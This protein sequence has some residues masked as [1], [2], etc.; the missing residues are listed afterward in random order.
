[1]DRTIPPIQLGLCCLN[2]VLRNPPKTGKVKP[3]PVFSSRSMVYKTLV[4]EGFSEAMNRGY[5]NLQ[6]IPTMLQWNLDH[7]MYVFRLSSELFAHI[8]NPDI[9]SLPEDT[10]T[11]EDGVVFR[12]DYR[13]Y[14]KLEW[15]QPLLEKV[16]KFARDHGIRL[17]FH[18]GQFNVLGTTDKAVLEKTRIELEIHARILDMMGMGVDSIMVIHGGGIYMD[19]SQRER[20][21][22]GR[23]EA[24]YGM[25]PIP[26]VSETT[27]VIG[28]WVDNFLTM[29][30][31]VQRRLVLENCEKS[32]SLED[33]IRVS[34]VLYH[35]TGFTK[36]IPVV[37]DTHHYSC[38]TILHPDE[39]QRPVDTLMFHVMETWISRGIKPKCHI[40]EQGSGKIG[41]HSDFV[42]VITPELIDIYHKFRR[43]GKKIYYKSQM[44]PEMIAGSSPVCID[45]MIEAKAKEQAILHLHGKAEYGEALGLEN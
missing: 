6:D 10:W 5:R 36:R 29:P 18:P 44:T 14:R 25:C 37:Y 11:R 30:D 19:K 42:E 41:H 27:G 26:P 4:K 39:T 28:R 34:D 40:S 38:Y 33:C 16:G 2:T 45:I 12:G 31:N 24:K 32:Y 9:E 23:I 8:S 1:M 35:R 15:C 7:R 20:G 3:E 22:E 17:T 13:M 21:A 43:I